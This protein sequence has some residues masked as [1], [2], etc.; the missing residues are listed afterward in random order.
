MAAAAAK[1]PNGSVALEEQN[2]EGN[3]Y[4][5]R[6]LILPSKNSKTDLG[7]VVL[8]NVPFIDSGKKRANANIHTAWL[9]C[10]SSNARYYADRQ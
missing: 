3:D 7:L 5:T 4:I 9:T 2:L 6:E 1:L 10:T 8:M